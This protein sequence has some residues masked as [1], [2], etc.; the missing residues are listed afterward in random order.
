MFRFE[1]Q[2]N[3]GQPDGYADLD[4]TGK[5]PLSELP[6]IPPTPP[7]SLIQSGTGSPVGTVTPTAPGYLYIDTTSGAP[8]LYFA[9]GATNADWVGVSGF[10]SAAGV[11]AQAAADQINLENVAGNG[12]GIN[13]AG[14]VSV[15][16]GTGQPVH[17]AGQAVNDGLTTV[18]DGA[19]HTKLSFYGAATVTQPAAITAPTGGVVIDTQARA[20]IVSILNALGAAAGGLGLT[21]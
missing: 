19:G 12:V 4:S 20:A 17:I 7:P 18:D 16:S 2:Q 3:K 5:V 8:G 9:T 11:T 21:S 15:T 10:N 1:D 13:S 14:Q 6:P